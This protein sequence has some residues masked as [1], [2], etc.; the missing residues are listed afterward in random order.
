[1]TSPRY[2]LVLDQGSTSSRAV[3]YT[4]AGRITYLARTPLPSLIPGPDRVEH[5]PNLLL[6]SQLAALRRVLTWLGKDGAK[7]IAAMGMTNQR[8]TFLLWDRRTG[9][10]VGRAISWQ[11]RSG[12]AICR[13]MARRGPM[14]Q[15]RTGL[16]LTPHSTVGKLSQLMR[17]RPDIRKKAKA[18]DLLFGTV[19]TYLIWK[20]T[21]G[22]VHATDHTNASRTLMMSLSTREWDP[23]L[24]DLFDIP[25]A[26]LP[27][28]RPTAALY[29]EALVG[30]RTIPIFSSIGDQ[31]ASLIGQ[32]GYR[33]GHLA[34][35]Y[36]TGGFALWNIGKRPQSRTRLLSTIAW[37]SAD[38]M[39]YALEGTVNSVGSAIL[40]L[41]QLGWIREPA[42]IDALCR[43][44]RQEV[45]AIPSL[46]GLGSP[47]YAPVETAFF[48]LNRQTTRADLVRGVMT[49]IAMLMKDNYEQMCRERHGRPRII[50]AG[51]GAAQSRWLLQC[52]ADLL[53]KEIALSNVYETT[54][55]GAA[56]LAGLA[57]GFW[58]NFD[59]LDR[60]TRPAARYR[61]KLSTREV[62][63]AEQQ[64]RRA[65]ELARMWTTN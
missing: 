23:A 8:S 64:W 59:E 6:G 31:Q 7:Q 43:A 48:G 5:D 13:E 12:A 49:G 25:S 55:R 40:W 16:R 18:G 17:H 33:P 42:E 37:S 11:D 60:L 24:L 46:S 39:H 44:S 9:R 10:P 14:I 2:L 51:G 1:M 36:G 15:A 65:L 29:G 41:K 28:I 53:R 38:T 62:K 32:G 3:L 26:L 56:Y 34:L 27:P 45:S 35:T 22:A 57:C 52:Q 30:R 50:S 21:G 19:N 63:Q 61:P 58:E 47:H 20:L 54:S 4:R